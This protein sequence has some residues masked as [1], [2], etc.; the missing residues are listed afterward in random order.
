MLALYYKPACPFCRRVLAVIDRLE[1]DV[2]LRDIEADDAYA[3]EL[4]A[5]GGK[6]Q[7]PYLVDETQGVEM[8]ESDDIVAHL[9]KH[10]S[11]APA[12]MVARPRV[13]VG[14]STCLSCEG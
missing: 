4:I 6:R 2:E 5:R 10:Y 14:G 7:V 12:A 9:Q 8:Y 11:G 3:Q 1:L 13:H